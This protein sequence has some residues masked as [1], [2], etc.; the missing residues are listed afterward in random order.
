M[1]T[2]K[3]KE[4]RRAEE[5]QELLDQFSTYER[6]V[7]VVNSVEGHLKKHYSD[8]LQFFD[9]YPEIPRDG[10]A[11]LTPDFTI[12]FKGE[13]AVICEAKRGMGSS[14]D[15][16]RD[17][18]NQL[19]SYDDTLALRAAPGDAYDLKSADHD[20][21][22][23]LNSSYAPKETKRI[24]P[25][26]SDARKD[27]KLNRSL[28]VFGVHYD[29]QEAQARWVYNWMPGS[30]KFRDEG[31]PEGRRLSVRHQDE[32]DP[33]VVFPVTFSQIHA[34]HYFCNDAPPPIYLAVVLWSRVFRSML[35]I[36]EQERWVLDDNLH[37]TVEFRATVKEIKDAA[38]DRL[39]YS[40]RANQVRDAMK[41]LERGHL[42][43]QLDKGNSYTIQYR[44]FSPRPEDEL[45]DEAASEIKLDSVRRG[46][47]NAIVRGK[48]PQKPRTTR[49]LRTR[50]RRGSGDGQLTLG[51]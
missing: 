46:I 29:T 14:D 21:L 28:V 4:A 24:K 25:L 7:S 6:A 41:L 26:L 2:K 37:G 49:P 44:C 33:I 27:G 38:N 11:P 50:R 19:L 3:S 43:K 36:G 9:R 48:R 51:L 8:L 23:I 30:E 15:S 39:S 32:A 20:I 35:P 40:L 13:Y 22:V 18:F 5:Q 42:V 12:V 31:L 16:L 17:R 47:V 45:S 34:V 1:A 10:L